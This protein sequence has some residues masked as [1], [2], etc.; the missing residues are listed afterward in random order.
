MEVFFG[1]KWNNVPNIQQTALI[2]LGDCFQKLSNGYFKSTPHRVNH[3]CKSKDRYSFP[4]FIYPQL[5]MK[6]SEQETC[7]SV[8]L[9]NFKGIWESKMGAGRAQELVQ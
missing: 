2:N 1:N 9:N 7:E 3:I 8:M 4:F 6:I 5:D